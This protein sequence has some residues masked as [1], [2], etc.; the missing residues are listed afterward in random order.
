MRYSKI[1]LLILLF[2]LSFIFCSQSQ[3]SE[4]KADSSS[5]E[6]KF[7]VDRTKLEASV[8]DTIYAIQYNPPL[9]WK[10]IP[11]EIFAQ[12]SQ[13]L[14]QQLSE[15]KVTLQPISIYMNQ[16]KG[17][18]LSVAVV[19]SLTGSFS[20][21]IEA[22]EKLLQNKFSTATLQKGEFTKDTLKFVQFL[23]Q[24][25][26]LITFKLLFQNSQHKLIQFDYIVPK[27]NY[28]SEVKSIESSIGSIK[29]IE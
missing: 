10:A 3:Q 25:E 13:Q 21:K 27:E 9:E 17:V 8:R 1:I 5:T 6:M 19:D 14:S 7:E 29:T 26:N 2:F 23:I 22:Y 24:K 28:V 16:P 12:V 11:S 4:D 20:E 15:E 18:L